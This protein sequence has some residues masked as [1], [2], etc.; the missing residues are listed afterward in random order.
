MRINKPILY[1]RMVYKNIEIFPY[2]LKIDFFLVFNCCKIK[3]ALMY[4]GSDALFGQ[5]GCIENVA[6]K[7]YVTFALC[8]IF[9]VG[10]DS[11]NFSLIFL[12]L[13]SH[14]Y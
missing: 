6:G 4:V 2:L 12:L 5:N 9:S 8:V 1:R 3:K 11:R 7:L 13:A 14:Y 10:K